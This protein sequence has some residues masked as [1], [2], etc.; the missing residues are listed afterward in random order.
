MTAP[1]T[2]ISYSWTS[3]E[4]EQWV[5][6]LATQLRESGVDVIFD[7]WDLKEGDDA[8]AF[9]ETIVTDE[10][11]EKVVLVLHKVYAKKADGRKGGVTSSSTTLAGSARRS[12][13]PIFTAPTMKPPSPI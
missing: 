13:R 6:D 12:Q 2:F 11:I 5:L 7:K 9:M 1:K 8:I 10:S 4:H 3:P